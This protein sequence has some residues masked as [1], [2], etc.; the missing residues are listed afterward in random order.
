MRVAT[1]ASIANRRYFRLDFNSCV[2]FRLFVAP[3]ESDIPPKPTAKDTVDPAHT[4]SPIRRAQRRRLMREGREHH[5][6]L[7]AALQDSDENPTPLLPARARPSVVDRIAS[8]RH[9]EALENLLREQ[10]RR[11]ERRDDPQADRSQSLSENGPPRSDSRSDAPPLPSYMPWGSDLY[12]SDAPA[13]APEGVS[14]L[15]HVVST[16]HTNI[17]LRSTLRPR[18]SYQVVYRTSVDG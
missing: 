1:A 16:H 18:N 10:R 12:P 8:S 7:L 2:A 11:L 9:E 5:L 17:T 4:R 14:P 13:D 15:S 3:V 6:R